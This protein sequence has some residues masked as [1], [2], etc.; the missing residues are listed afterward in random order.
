MTRKARIRSRWFSFTDWQTLVPNVPR[1]KKLWFYFSTMHNDNTTDE[2]SSLSEMIL[3]Y[4][5]AK[6]TVDRIEQFCHNY[7]GQKRTKN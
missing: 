7:S 5:A 2:G 6:A 4:N 3:D 1:K